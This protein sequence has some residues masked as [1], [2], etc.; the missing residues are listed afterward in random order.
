M[1]TRANTVYAESGYIREVSA[2]SGFVVFDDNRAPLVFSI[3]ANG[4]KG[5][6]HHAKKMQEQI[7]ALITE[8]TLQ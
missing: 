2:L 7:V 3:I 4:V 8:H 5:T 6:V 1:S